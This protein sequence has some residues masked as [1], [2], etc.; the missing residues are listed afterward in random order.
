MP[1]PG[2]ISTAMYVSG[3]DPY[4]KKPIHVAR[5]HKER[6]RQRSMLFWWKR[7]EHPAIREALQTWGRTDLIGRGPEH[8]VPPG[9]AQGS[10]VRHAPEPTVGA[11]GMKV[12]RATKSEVD[13]ERWEGIAGS[14]A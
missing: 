2:T 7:E 8:L 11:M 12:E 6:A 1:T 13:E 9:P 4:S 3:V 5:G 10:W 14:I